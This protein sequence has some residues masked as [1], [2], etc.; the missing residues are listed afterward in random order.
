MSNIS[1][2]NLVS[3]NLSSEVDPTSFV[4]DL[5]EEQ[6]NLSGGMCVASDDGASQ[7]CGD[8]IIYFPNKFDFGKIIPKRK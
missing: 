2:E 8:V 3:H 7:G 1:V 6:I 5:S 4:C